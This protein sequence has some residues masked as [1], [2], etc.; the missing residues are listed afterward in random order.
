MTNDPR[1]QMPIKI[2]WDGMVGE[3]FVDGELWSEVEYSEKHRKWCIQ[4]AEGQCLAHKEHIRA[5]EDD[6]DGAVALAK[7]MIRDGRLPSP[8]EAKKT[9]KE[10][11]K[12]DRERRAKQPSEIRRR[13]E[14]HETERLFREYWETKNTD[15]GAEPLYEAVADMLDFN[16]PELWKSN[17]FARLRLRLITTVRAAI[18]DCEYSLRR[19]RDPETVERLARAREILKLLCPDERLEA[20][21]AAK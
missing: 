8:E 7:A 10:R 20:D 15:E 1:R 13:A 3:L 2:R 6:K 19:W 14:R 5:F 18:A 12:R 9:R 4:D 21:E 16:N 17:S 11:L